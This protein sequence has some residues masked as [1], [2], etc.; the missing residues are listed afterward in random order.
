MTRSTHIS[1]SV[2]G[3]LRNW[4]KKSYHG[5]L[6][7]KETGRELSFEEAKEALM[8]ELANGVEAIPLMEC[9]NFDPKK[10]C[11]GHEEKPT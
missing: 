3:A 11:L 9:D 1:M 6:N 2:R 8:A 10:G 5:Y 7:D 4:T